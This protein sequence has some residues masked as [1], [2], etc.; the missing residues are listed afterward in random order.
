MEQKERTQR[1]GSS[2]PL[3]LV[4]ESMVRSQHRAH[5]FCLPVLN[6]RL[7]LL[8]YNGFR[9]LCAS[10]LPIPVS[11]TCASGLNWDLGL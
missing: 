11:S 7:Y 8:Q 2:S 10:G 4:R 9:C 6:S 3:L 1:A 5:E